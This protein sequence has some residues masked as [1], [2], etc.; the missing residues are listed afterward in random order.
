VS[1]NRANHGVATIA[2]PAGQH[3]PDRA[4]L[5]R[6][7]ARRR[8]PAAT[9]HQPP[10][11]SSG[12]RAA[13][14][15]N[16]A[17]LAHALQRVGRA[18]QTI[19][20]VA[21]CSDQP[22]RRRILTQLN[23]GES[24]HALRPRRLPRPPRRTA[25]ALPGSL[26]RNVSPAANERRYGADRMPPRDGIRHGR[27]HCWLPLRDWRAGVRHCLRRA[28]ASVPDQQSWAISQG[29]LRLPDCTRCSSEQS[30]R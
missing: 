30:W 6:P 12:R 17:S 3:A 29:P 1:L 11:S 14:P 19:H 25:P 8:Q 5:R 22:F 15:A 21:D 20:L 26:V 24:R 23:R 27:A 2:A 4:A 10:A 7:A 28:A 13:T 9:R 18:A 16:H